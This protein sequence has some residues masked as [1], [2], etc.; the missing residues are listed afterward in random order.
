MRIRLAMAT[1][2]AVGLTAAAPAAALDNGGARTP[3]TGFNDWN[4]F[5][6]NVSERLIEQSADAMIASGMKAAG[7]RYVNIDDCWLEKWR[8]GAGDLVPDPSKFPHGIAAVAAYVH[9]RGLK[10]GIY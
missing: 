8:D 9:A 6:C 5:G 7:Y 2:V 3:P 10:L 1:A 4:A